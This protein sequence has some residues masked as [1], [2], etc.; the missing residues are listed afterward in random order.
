VF[1]LS[2]LMLRTVDKNTVR[3][4]ESRPGMRYIFLKM[5]KSCGWSGRL[6]TVAWRIGKEWSHDAQASWGAA[7]CAPT[8]ANFRGVQ[9]GRVA[10]RRGVTNCYGAAN[11]CGD[12][13][14]SA[15]AAAVRSAATTAAGVRGAATAGVARGGRC[16]A[17]R[18]V[19]ARWGGIGA[20]WS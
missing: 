8:E 10:N 9:I 11:R 7:C 17:W 4:K 16:V 1:V 19:S 18:G 3:G 6:E 14:V 13:M 20:A 12:L 15:A 5:L 2:G